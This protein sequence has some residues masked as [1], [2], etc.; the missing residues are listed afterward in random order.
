MNDS[1]N[2]AS[3]SREIFT[4]PNILVYIR[5]LLIP[6]QEESAQLRDMRED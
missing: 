6:V 5:V 3:L 4:V 1:K 2:A